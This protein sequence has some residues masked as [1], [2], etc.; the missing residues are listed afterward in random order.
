MGNFSFLSLGLG[1]KKIINSKSYQ[2]KIVKPM[3]VFASSE[4]G[5]YFTLL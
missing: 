5:L 4:F 3:L 2:S 1:P